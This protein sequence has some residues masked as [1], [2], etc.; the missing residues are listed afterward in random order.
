MPK[1]GIQ[2]QKRDE[3]MTPKEVVDFFGPFDYDPATTKKQAEHLGIPNYD[4]IETDGLKTD[5]NK[6]GRI[7]INPPFTRK[8]EF[9]RKAIKTPRHIFFL[10]P[11]EYMTT[12][13][14][15]EI[16]KEYDGG[17]IMWLPNGRIKFSDGSSKNS[18]AFGSVI[19]EL[20]GDERRVKH[21]R[22]Y[23]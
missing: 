15:H 10:M 20:W 23:E 16:M 13:Q 22:L 3:W 19:L 17:Y 9:L 1:A 2:F 12:K 4:T 5:W 14:F 8:E 11:I 6:Y 21:W 18:P 7:F